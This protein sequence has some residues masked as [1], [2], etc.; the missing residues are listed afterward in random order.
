MKVKNQTPKTDYKQQFER[1]IAQARADVQQNGRSWAEAA[2]ET[3]RK[4]S[5][6]FTSIDVAFFWSGYA[7]GLGQIATLG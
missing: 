6:A 5:T 7:V 1:G 3:Q 2:L 4:K